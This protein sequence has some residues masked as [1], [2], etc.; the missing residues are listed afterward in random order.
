MINYWYSIEAAGLKNVS[1]LYTAVNTSLSRFQGK[2]KLKLRE[3][4]KK[5]SV[6]SKDHGSGSKIWGGK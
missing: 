6:F 3:Q 1:T 5:I 2:F 4:K